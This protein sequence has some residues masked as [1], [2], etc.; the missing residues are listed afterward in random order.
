MFIY[1]ILLFLS[2]FIFVYH[3][4]KSQIVIKDLDEEKYGSKTDDITK[5][6][7]VKGPMFFA[8]AGKIE[9]TF[10]N[11]FT[12]IDEL[13]ISLD[14]VNA[15]DTSGTSVFVEQIEA[16]RKRNAK[17]ILCGASQNVINMLNKLNVKE[18]V[19]EEN[20]VETI[21]EAIDKTI[22]K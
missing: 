6:M 2:A 22:E 1:Y 13:I 11:S 21:D 14:G 19:G 3:A 8:N 7:Y 5:I 4:S 16:L 10:K 15:V 9:K 12:K 18:I 20:I 17:I